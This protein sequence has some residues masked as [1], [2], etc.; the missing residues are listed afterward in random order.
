MG[1]ELLLQ[2]D[3]PPPP[4]LMHHHQTESQ[5]QMATMGKE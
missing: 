4:H 5:T 3:A 1:A 2:I